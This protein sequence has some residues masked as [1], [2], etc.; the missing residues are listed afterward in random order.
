MAGM[1]KQNGSNKSWVINPRQAEY[2]DVNYIPDSILFKF[3]A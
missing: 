1:K 2:V 3:R